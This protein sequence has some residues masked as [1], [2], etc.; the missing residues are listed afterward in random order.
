MDEFLPEIGQVQADR[1]IL[2]AAQAKFRSVAQ[3]NTNLEKQNQALEM[4]LV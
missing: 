2:V 3:N 1:S 4:Q